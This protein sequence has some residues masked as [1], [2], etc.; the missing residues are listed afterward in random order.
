MAKKRAIEGTDLSKVT[1]KLK[2]FLG[3]VPG[4]Y[5]TL[6]YALILIFVVFL[7][8]F[9]PGIRHWG[10]QVSV[11]STPGEAAV[12]VDGRYVGATPES[13]FISGGNHDLSVRRPFYTAV[14]N[15]IDV[16]GR[17]FGSLFVPRRETFSY[18]LELSDLPGMVKHTFTDFSKWALVDRI[19]PN[20]ELPPILQ[21]AVSGAV[22]STNFS[23]RE[24]LWRLIES[25]MGDVNNQY[26]L[27]DFTAAVSALAGT[28]ATASP[29][30]LL[31]TLDASLKLGS[32][33]PDLPLWLAHSLP[34]H[35]R[36]QFESSNEFARAKSSY[37]TRLST[38]K[39]TEGP[40]GGTVAR[41][42]G[43]RFIYVPGG[44]YIMGAP[45]GQIPNSLDISL[46]DLPH[47]EK[48]DP[49]YMLSTEITHGEYAQF[50]AQNPT[51]APN[52]ETSLAASGLVT[53]NYLKGWDTYPGPD[54]PQDY[55]SFY[56]AQAFCE[57]LQK[58]LPPS[59][60]GYVV[61]LP[62][63]SEWEWAA[64]M[65]VSPSASVFHDSYDSLQPAGT[66]AA[67]SLGIRDLLGSLWEWTSDWYLPTR[68]Y[69]TSIDGSSSLAD[70]L[71]GGAAE[72]AVRGGSWASAQDSITY[73]TR[74]S[75]PPDWCTPY[76]GFRPIIARR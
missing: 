38:F 29:A 41:V 20:Y 44:S 43:M 64:R 13:V 66:G 5:L 50:L 39:A 74:G 9:L 30:Q 46:S 55:V 40:G 58:Q 65:N 2:P 59:L 25:S 67:D 61:R 57:W 48:V 6:L 75:Q 54:Y 22:E 31:A 51:W 53:A 76:L 32:A 70:S 11:R 18:Q 4:L 36:T 71:V 56:A 72:K 34:E 24:D 35:E 33:Y 62:T 49:Y 8:L 69:L 7:L 37:L 21:T 73:T 23:G 28:G 42:D 68:S 3:M 16:G 12:Y 27:K 52:A 17:L 19:L 26:L 47:I 10:S 60:A 63:Q 15:R 1:V 45:A 14:D